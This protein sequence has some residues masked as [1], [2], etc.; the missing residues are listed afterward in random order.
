MNILLLDGN[1]RYN[2]E[3]LPDEIDDVKLAILDN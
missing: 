2:L 1:V 3:Q